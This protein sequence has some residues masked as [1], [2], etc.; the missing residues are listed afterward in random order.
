MSTRHI[1]L[2]LIS[3]PD[4]LSNM[5]E[6]WISF[7]PLQ[8]RHERRDS[9]FWRLQAVMGVKGEEYSQRPLQC[10]W[11]KGWG[12]HHNRA[13]HRHSACSKEW[14]CGGENSFH[15][16]LC[17][18][19]RRLHHQGWVETPAQGK[20]AI[21]S[22]DL[23]P[24]LRVSYPADIAWRIVLTTIICT[25][26]QLALRASCCVK[27]TRALHNIVLSLLRNLG[28]KQGLYCTQIFQCCIGGPLWKALCLG[29]ALKVIVASSRQTFKTS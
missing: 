17:L 20:S 4:L 9:T 18:Q 26:L 24:G 28:W 5:H 16:E 19:W 1:S 2:W 13:A 21:R 11:R 3:S 12:S 23:D 15:M 10:T 25:L 14:H 8:N 27:R 7:I 6:L 29:L 22:Y